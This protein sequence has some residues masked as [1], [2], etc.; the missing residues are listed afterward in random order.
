[1]ET[2]FYK[3]GVKDGMEV[4][5]KSIIIDI[6]DDILDSLR[7]ELEDLDKQMTGSKADETIPALKEY[8]RNLL[9]KFKE[10]LKLIEDGAE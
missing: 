1:M 9:I 7:R 5:I 8:Q 10:K 2:S 4:S 6:Q 3:K